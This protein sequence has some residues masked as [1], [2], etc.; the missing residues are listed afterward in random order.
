[1]DNIP[2]TIITASIVIIA[3]LAVLIFRGGQ[4]APEQE[5]NNPN[6]VKVERPNGRRPLGNNAEGDEL[7]EFVASS[8]E[9]KQAMQGIAKAFLSGSED[10][11]ADAIIE[12]ESLGTEDILALFDTAMRIKNPEYR[13]DIITRVQALPHRGAVAALAK[14]MNDRDPSVRQL[15]IGA[16]ATTEGVLHDEAA[17]A[18]QESKD[19]LTLEEE[20]KAQVAAAIKQAINDS[21]EEVRHEALEALP[22]FSADFQNYGINTAIEADDNNVRSNALFLAQGSFNKETISAIITAIGDKDPKIREQAIDFMQ[23]MFEQEFTSTKEARE[24]WERNSYKYDYDL[25]EQQEDD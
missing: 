18:K 15:A 2:K 7:Q 25:V 22:M 11:I 13:R 1:M 19:R 9:S 20:D 16:L 10:E 17:K 4:E 3:V 21:D 8:K 12:M 14:A 24:W 5:D 6:A 23:H